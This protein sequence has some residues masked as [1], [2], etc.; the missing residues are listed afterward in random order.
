MLYGV[1]GALRGARGVC[2]CVMVVIEVSCHGDVWCSWFWGVTRGA[3][4]RLV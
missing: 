4:M 1:F 2:G 3:R